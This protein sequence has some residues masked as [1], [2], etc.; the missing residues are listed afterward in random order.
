MYTQSLAPRMNFL[1]QE[2]WKLSYEKQTDRQTPPKLQTT[3]H[4]SSRVVKNKKCT[5]YRNVKETCLGRCDWVDMC[6]QFWLV[7]FVAAALRTF[8]KNR[9]MLRRACVALRTGNAGNY[10]SRN[11]TKICSIVA[12]GS[13]SLLTSPQ[14]AVDSYSDSV[15]QN[16]FA[17]LLINSHIAFRILRKI[18]DGLFCFTAGR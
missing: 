6:Q 9:N 5:T 2:F 4:A 13:K 18:N 14:W 17:H 11:Y 15:I 10:H 12:V 1:G 3:H 8:R 16:S 7:A